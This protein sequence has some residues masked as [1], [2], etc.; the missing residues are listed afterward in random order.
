MKFFRSPD[1]PTDANEDEDGDEYDW[2]SF[3]VNEKLTIKIRGTVVWLVPRGACFKDVVAVEPIDENVPSTLIVVARA[4]EQH[5]LYENRGLWFHGGLNV[6]H[7][8]ARVYLVS[9]G[10]IGFTHT[11]E[12]SKKQSMDADQVAIVA[13]GIIELGGPLPGYVQR[14]EYE[15]FV[16][17]E[18]AD[19]LIALGALPPLTA[20]TSVSYLLARSTWAEI[21]PR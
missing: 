14:V 16:M 21:T 13:G 15:S 12:D 17:D 6:T 9:E 19:E 1:T 3:C 5:E 4:N 2:Y 10:D 20:A 8:H 7:D 11:G 18:L